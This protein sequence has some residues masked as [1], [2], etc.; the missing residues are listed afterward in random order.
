[1][2]RLSLDP[3]GSDEGALPLRQGH[4]IGWLDDALTPM[5]DSIPADEMRT[6]VLAIRATLGIEALV[7][8]T[9]IGGLT[10][11]EAVELMRTS[12][13]TLLR[14]ALAE[15]SAAAHGPSD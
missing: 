14:S 11:E 8:L 9:D 10:R 13:R 4:V 7:W 2:L 12:A 3:A 6:L 15:A 1:M 5:R